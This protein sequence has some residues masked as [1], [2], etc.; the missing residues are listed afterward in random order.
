MKI[1]ILI[2]V[3]AAS[4]CAQDYKAMF[5]PNTS[6]IEK[7]TFEVSFY[8]DI[9]EIDDSYQKY[10]PIDW[11]TAAVDPTK[12]LPGSVLF[13]PGFV[14]EKLANGTYH[15]GYFLAHAVLKNYPASAIKIYRNIKVSSVESRMVYKVQ[16][17]MGKALRI[18]F[19]KEY[20]SNNDLKTYEMVASDFTE[21]MKEGNKN[22]NNLYERLEYYSE[23][24]KGT[25]YLIYNLGEGA[26]SKVDPDP[27]IDFAR[28][29]CMT[30]T[31]H[32]LALA[33]SDNYNEMY[34]NLQKI[35]Y[36]G[37]QIGY[38][39][40][41]HYALVDWLP[42]NA[43]LLQDVTKEIAKGNTKQL[44]KTIDRTSFYKN[45]GLQGDELKEAPGKIK[46]TIDYIP[47]NKLAGIMGNLKGAEIFSIVTKHPAVFSAHMGIV[48]KD[49][50]DNVILR[51]ASSSQT[52]REVIDERFTDYI[53]HLKKSKSRV[54]MVFMRVKE[55]FTIPQ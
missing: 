51:H 40:R 36:K 54:G 28:T 7:G 53:K 16:G 26:D 23:K 8:S 6:Y 10:I 15:D 55:N 39:T 9:S 47:T 42:N 3:F 24:G 43:W 5:A 31:E 25:P 38:V 21:L 1:Y 41:N 14:G 34:D 49:Q 48:V 32:T 44:T 13:I 4:L 20:E 33:I 27:T 46:W 12:I 30:F 11:R 22:L 29:D 17:A 52:T 2:L 45:N 37:G 19:R 50:W 35:R 18:R